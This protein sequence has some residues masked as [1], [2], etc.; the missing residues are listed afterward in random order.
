MVSWFQTCLQAIAAASTLA[1][2][3]GCRVGPDYQRPAVP[4]QS[5]WKNP[6]D[7]DSQDLLRANRHWWSEFNDPILDVLVAE[8]LASSP[9][10]KEAA[11]RVLEARARRGITRADRLPNL[12]ATSDYSYRR[13]SGNASPFS[14]LNQDAF[15]FGGL[16]FR[17]AWQLDIWGKY[18]R[19]IEAASAE[20]Q[21]S[22]NDRVG[23]MLTLQSDV[24]STYIQIRALQSRLGVA[25]EN[26]QLQRRILKIAE[27]RVVAGLS[28]PTDAEQARAS[29]Y[30]IEAQIPTLVTQ[31]QQTENRL[32]VLLGKPPE[33]LSEQ[34]QPV[35]DIP[36]PAGDPLVGVPAHLLRR[37]PDVRSAE[38]SLAA[39]TA[40]VGVA[41]A[42]LYPQIALN[43]TL[44]VD[45]TKASRLFTAPSLAHDI[46]P[47]L[48]WKLL[49]FGQVRNQIAAQEARVKQALW[50]YRSIVLSAVEEVENALIAY[51]QEQQRIEA[52][53]KA[54]AA[55]NRAVE[56]ALKNY[57]QGLVRF[58]TVL[59]S[60]RTQLSLQD[61]LVV[62]K[63]NLATER[64]ALYVALGGG[65]TVERVELIETQPCRFEGLAYEFA[66]AEQP[67]VANA[68]SGP[69]ASQ[70][71]GDG[72]RTP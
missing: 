3:L 7:T 72:E 25:E 48:S 4:I 64:I 43:G 20:I 17:T 19:A 23:V 68:V 34:W 50:R 31:L 45:A 58:Q 15:N 26:L 39:E 62:S 46:G 30:G 54:V 42:D 32:S 47:S 63:A 24:A 13:I 61:Q 59:D 38:R 41:V 33:N 14:L 52:L 65:W 9:D 22:E 16:G 66:A 8:A 70:A 10:L 49:Y 67:A 6:L 5:H 56:L 53:E 11:Y 1:V 2:L 29:L 44:S 60:Q 51:R 21:V 71:A 57:R 28:S 69:N 12:D 18:Q 35:A 55:A 27:Q 37:R 36:L 40:R